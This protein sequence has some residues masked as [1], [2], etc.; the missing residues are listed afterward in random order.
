MVRPHPSVW[1]LV[2]GIMVCYLLFIVYLLFQ[3]VG[4]ARQFLKV[5]R[6]Q[7]MSVLSCLP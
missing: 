7:Q 3:T 2:H 1:R 6:P 5:R 4:D